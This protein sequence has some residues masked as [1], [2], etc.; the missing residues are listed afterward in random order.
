MKTSNTN[1]AEARQDLIARI[2]GQLDAKIIAI[3]GYI[4]P[5]GRVYSDTKPKYG[6]RAVAHLTD[7][8]AIADISEA[9]AKYP[10]P[11]A[12]DDIHL[13]FVITGKGAARSDREEPGVID[14][15]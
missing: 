3:K 13:S 14:I 7:S 15:G 8:S 6:L 2:K 5:D 12:E 10:Y 4:A 11:W 9:A 1:S